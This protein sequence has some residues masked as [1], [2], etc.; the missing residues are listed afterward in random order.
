MAYADDAKTEQRAVFS[1]RFACPV[2][3]FTID[4]IEPRLFSF[5]NPFGACPSC[6]GLGTASHFDAELIVPDKGQTLRS[7][8]LA[9]W[10]S[11][12]SKYYLQTLESLARHF[13]FSLDVP[14]NKLDK[15][16]QTMILQGSGTEA[17]TMQYDDGLRSYRTQK[18]F[19]GIIPNLT[20]R[21]RETDSSWVREELD[22]FRANHPCDVCNGKRLKPESLAVKVQD[23]DISDIASLSIQDALAWFI[24]LADTLDAQRAEIATRILK[25]INERL[26][27]LANVGLNYLNLSRNSGTLSGGESQRIRLASQIGSG[28]TGVLYV[29]DEP[30]NRSSPKR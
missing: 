5:N 3:G 13:S 26:G 18:P 2:S 15:T 28:L 11:S 6:D 30:L 19:E 7:G 4:E 23:K 9:P 21:Y 16:V 1:A 25:E 10:A 24:A 20:R 12:T 27:F 8:A 14:F 17:V 29:L 22:K